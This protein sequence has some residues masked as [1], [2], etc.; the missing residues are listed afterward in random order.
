MVAR[1]VEVSFLML[2]DILRLLNGG[3]RGRGSGGGLL[4]RLGQLLIDEDR[5]RSS[6]HERHGMSRF[7]GWRDNDDRGYD[8]RYRSDDDDDDRDARRF[9]Y[10]DDDGRRSSYG[11]RSKG[12]RSRLDLD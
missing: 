6:R 9:G 11:K 5:R 10:D 4:S 7:S 12:W 8:R 3:K 1:S 2:G